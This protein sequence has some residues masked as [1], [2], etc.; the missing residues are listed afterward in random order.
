MRKQKGEA[1]GWQG[2]FLESK[3][4]RMFS[5]RKYPCRPCRPGMWDKQRAG[6]SRLL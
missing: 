4:T 6:S 1:H 2:R 5:V 3:R